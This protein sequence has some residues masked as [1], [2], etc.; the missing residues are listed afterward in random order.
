M[1]LLL[2]ECIDFQI[3]TILFIRRLHQRSDISE[4]FKDG[5]FR[6]FLKEMAVRSAQYDLNV[7]ELGW[8]TQYFGVEGFENIKD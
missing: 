4:F 7:E 1:H 8:V 3:V 2:K 6:L 5:N